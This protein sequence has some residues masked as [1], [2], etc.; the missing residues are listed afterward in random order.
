MA[1]VPAHHTGQRCAHKQ[2]SPPWSQGPD[3]AK[4]WRSV[5][6]GSQARC[7]KGHSPDPRGNASLWGQLAVGLSPNC[8][9]H[10]EK[11]KSKHPSTPQ[12]HAVS[13]S[14]C[15]SI[16][17]RWRNDAR[18]GLSAVA[19]AGRAAQGGLAQPGQSR[20][21]MP[22]QRKGISANPQARGFGKRG[23]EFKGYIIC[24]QV[25]MCHHI[26]SRQS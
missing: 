5:N 25:V 9:F 8:L 12:P 13:V 15:R 16:S 7:P 1:D 3:S 17:S 24:S 21:E 10:K 19:A 22:P 11:K 18:V 23:E 14:R 4:S 2:R 20:A 6:N 26:Y